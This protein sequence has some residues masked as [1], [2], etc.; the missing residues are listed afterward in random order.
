[1]DRETVPSVFPR[2]ADVEAAPCILFSMLPHIERDSWDF[3][4]YFVKQWDEVNSS[5]DL[6]NGSPEFEETD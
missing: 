6:L 3:E 4:I 1:V 2:L 5:L